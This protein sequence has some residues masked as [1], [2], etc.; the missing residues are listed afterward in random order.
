MLE[1]FVLNL[2]TNYLSTYFCNL[3]REQLRVGLWAGSIVLTN[4]ELRRDA[5]DALRL[6][7]R[8]RGGRIGRLMIRVPWIHRMRSEPVRA[9]RGCRLHTHRACPTRA[10]ALASRRSCWSRSRTSRCSAACPTRPTR[11]RTG[12]ASACGSACGSTPRSC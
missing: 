3:K 7:V 6:P 4:L 1:T 5:L 8:L 2:F 11:R 10:P 12:G 9:P